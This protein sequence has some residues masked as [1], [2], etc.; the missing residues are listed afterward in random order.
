MLQ[1][2]LSSRSFTATMMVVRMIICC[3]SLAGAFFSQPSQIFRRNASIGSYVNAPVYVRIPL[4]DKQSK[5]YITRQETGASSKSSVKKSNSDIVNN[6]NKMPKRLVDALDLYPLLDNVAKYTGTKRGRNALLHL[7]THESYDNMKRKGFLASE[8]Y[9]ASRRKAMLSSMTAASSSFTSNNVGGSGSGSSRGNRSNMR[10]I[11]KIAESASEAQEEWALVKEAMSVLEGHNDM[12]QIRRNNAD[13]RRRNTRE[14]KAATMPLP[15]PPIYAADAK[16]PWDV[17]GAN[18]VVDTDDDEWLHH[19]LAGGFNGKLDLEHIL[20]ADQIVKRILGTFEWSNREAISRVAPKLADTFPTTSNIYGSNIDINMLKELQEEIEGTVT[21]AKGNKSFDYKNTFVFQLNPAKFPNLSILKQ[22]E[23]KIIKKMNAVVEKLLANKKY[24]SQLSGFSRRKPEPYELDGRV[25]VAASKEVA[26]RI[27][28]IRSHSTTGTFCYV[29][30]MEVVK[31]GNELKSIREEISKVEN[32][33]MEH[34]SSTIVRS[35]INI[36]R[37][38]DAVARLD[39]I[40]ARAAFGYTLN[41]F[42]PQVGSAGVIDVENFIHPVLATKGGGSKITPIDLK[43]SDDTHRA[44][45]IS[46]PNGKF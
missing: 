3:C 28:V 40:F 17:G 2:N 37:G 4:I 13:G 33:V 45:I 6:E 1:R 20:Q 34:L 11:I 35:A 5:L 7:V 41:G 27:G 24:L 36:N 21:I 32:E 43:L 12:M 16:T 42:I 8:T 31:M 29:E 39:T 44:L 22:K 46:G 14:S 19:I 15:L 10:Q 25:V 26:S 23:N 18:D 30:P 38:L 9:K